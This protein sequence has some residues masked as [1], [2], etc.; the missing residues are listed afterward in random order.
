MVK[1]LD[2]G[3]L[4]PLAFDGTVN[5]RPSWSPDGNSVIYASNRLGSNAKDLAMYSI[6]PDGIG[7]PEPLGLASPSATWSSDGT[8]WIYRTSNLEADQGNIM[9][10][11]AASDS[12]P[13]SLV[14]TPY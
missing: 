11:A 5:S 4:I 13:I 8:W 14:A 7:S 3:S 6:R 9:T 10:V 2:D 12:E 1:D